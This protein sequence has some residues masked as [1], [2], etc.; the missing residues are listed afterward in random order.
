M[1]PEFLNTYIDVRTANG[2]ADVLLDALEFQAAA[3][4]LYQAPPGSTTDGVSTPRFLWR[5]I[6]PNGDADFLPAVLHDAA[7][8]NGLLIYCPVNDTWRRANLTQR[9]ADRLLREALLA[10]GVG[11]LKR[12]VIY[13]ALRLF[14]GQ[15]FRE[16]RRAGQAAFDEGRNK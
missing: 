15:A 5:I 9:Q 12:N 11:F 13:F 16:D 1:K 14:G 6:P 8:R 4:T 3:G 10:N 2:L 7:Y